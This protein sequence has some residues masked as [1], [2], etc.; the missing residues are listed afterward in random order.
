MT[1]LVRTFLVAPFLVQPNEEKPMKMSKLEHWK[2]AQVELVN[3]SLVRENIIRLAWLKKYAYDVCGHRPASVLEFLL[4]NKPHYL[5]VVQVKVAKY[6]GLNGWHQ[7][8][9]YPDP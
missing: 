9:W 1:F 2:E 4:N 6:L 3:W 7:V 5:G 8:D